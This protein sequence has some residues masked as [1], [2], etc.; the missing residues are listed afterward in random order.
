MKCC[1]P[2][3]WNSMIA[4]SMTS[5]KR[6]L[7]QIHSDVW[8]KLIRRAN[9]STASFYFSVFTMAERSRRGTR[10]PGD[11][12]YLDRV[13]PPRVFGF[14]GKFSNLILKSKVWWSAGIR[15]LLAN[16][17]QQ[18]SIHWSGLRLKNNYN[19][20]TFRWSTSHFENS[21]SFPGLHMLISS[22]YAM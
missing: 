4:I 16:L 15:V 20:Y 3:W 7:L 5:N 8:L 12:N 17:L 2:S 11:E 6:H 1:L 14:G 13:L 9:F 19:K 10:T 18:H 21:W 22:A